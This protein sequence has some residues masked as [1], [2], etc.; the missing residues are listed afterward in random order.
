LINYDGAQIGIV[1]LEEARR[2]AEETG[3]DLVEVAPQATPPVCKIIDF[4]KILYEQKRKA[5]QAKKK[6]KQ[7]EVKEIKMQ[8]TIDPHD[9]EIKTR[10]VRDFIG[11]GHKVKVTI[12]YKGRGISHT[13]LGEQLIEKMLTQL[14]DV[15]EPEGGIRRTGRFQIIIL[16]KKRG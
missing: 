1:P 5:R 15:A 3:M 11:H 13:E 8:P 10:H 12:M 14:S 9:L 7:I 6:Q 2:R 16:T 4:K